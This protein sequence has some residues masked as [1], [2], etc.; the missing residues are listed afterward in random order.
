MK[1]IYCSKCG[2]VLNLSF[3]DKTCSCKCAGGKYLDILNAE[4]YGSAVPL[5]FQNKSFVDAIVENIMRGSNVEFTAFTI[6][7]GCKNFT[8]KE[9]GL[10]NE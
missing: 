3:E 5:G 4:Y 7:R 9:K 2:D 8:R 6:P 1:L 10:V